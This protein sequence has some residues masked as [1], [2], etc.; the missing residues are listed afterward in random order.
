MIIL[1]FDDAYYHW[2]L[3][4]LQS[5]SLHEPKTPVLC[6][7]ANL[8][9]SQTGEL[10][11]AHQRVSVTNGVSSVRT[12]ADQ[13][14]ARKPFVMLH[15]MN[16]YPD[17]PWYALLD[18]D[19]LIRRPLASLWSFLDKY[20]AALFITDGYENGK[21]YRQLITPSGI[22]L[23]RPD[24]RRL[25]DCWAKWHNYERPL[26]SIAPGEWY[27]DQITLAEAWIES[28]IRCARI[29]LE[30]YADDS[31]RDDSAIWHANVGD[32]KPEYYERFR[33]EF[34]RQC[35]ELIPSEASIR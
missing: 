2:G 11:S 25:I 14:A 34:R 15:A 17:A 10:E 23:V 16:C 5:L 35:S 21:Y 1:Q 24:A 12:H 27:W 28:G 18:A 26:Y 19:F 8:T 32:L 6:N 4:A 13:M 3:L 30:I 31:L 22:V 9:E 33:E 7:T 20:A 29:P